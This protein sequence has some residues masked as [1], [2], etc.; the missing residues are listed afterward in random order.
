MPKVDSLWR[1][2]GACRRGA[3]AAHILWHGDGAARHSHRQG[4]FVTGMDATAAPLRNLNRQEQ[5]ARI[6]GVP[7]CLAAGKRTSRCAEFFPVLPLLHEPRYPAKGAISIP[8]DRTR[9]RK[10]TR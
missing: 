7:G 2:A 4:E 1:A 9:D 10:S 8:R 5:A 6:A 3:L